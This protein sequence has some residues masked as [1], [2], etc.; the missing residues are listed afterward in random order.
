MHRSPQTRGGGFRLDRSAGLVHHAAVMGYHLRAEAA[1]GPREE[2]CATRSA[3][4][5]RTGV[6]SG[7]R[8]Y[9][10]ELGRWVNRDPIGEEGGDHLYAFS[11]NAN[12]IRHDPLGL[13]SD[14]FTI[15]DG[16]VSGDTAP[17]PSGVNELGDAVWRAP[18]LHG[19]GYRDRLGRAATS[20]GTYPT[21]PGG[22]THTHQEVGA[23][24]TSAGAKVGALA[25][26]AEGMNT[27]MNSHELRM[28]RRDCERRFD[29]ANYL[30]SGCRACCVLSVIS[31]RNSMG[32]LT[33]AHASGTLFYR[34]CAY[35]R[36]QI[37][38]GNPM[39]D[40]FNPRRHSSILAR[41][42]QLRFQFVTLP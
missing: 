4:M 19:A 7:Y 5:S 42:H 41:G 29:M 12:L 23:P 36:Q 34:S 38:A 30:S 25:M 8:Y 18:A 15:H 3:R 32:G 14:S 13:Q 21:T 27:A 1:A 37:A 39:V 35:V 10:P 6:G 22:P 40:D 9:S 31:S 24:T 33:V 11:R 28:A 20:P 26:I 2:G 16:R 17:A